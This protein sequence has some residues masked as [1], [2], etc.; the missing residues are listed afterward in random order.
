MNGREG[1]G[2]DGDMTE[3]TKA[4]GTAGSYGTDGLGAVGISAASYLVEGTFRAPLP[5]VE[6]VE[7]GI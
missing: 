7:A 5:A 6:R 3:G 2:E 1:L 4:P